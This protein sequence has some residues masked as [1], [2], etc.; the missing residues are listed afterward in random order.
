MVELRKSSASR[1]GPAYE[2]AHGLSAKTA[3]TGVDGADILPG[4]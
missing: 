1:R 3:S 2:K 4:Y